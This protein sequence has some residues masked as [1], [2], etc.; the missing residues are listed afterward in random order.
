MATMRSSS[1]RDGVTPIGG[2]GSVSRHQLQQQPSGPD[3]VD[4]AAT[5]DQLTAM[6]GYSGGGS[7]GLQHLLLAS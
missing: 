5:V 4:W 1:P 7:S 2:G 3:G 6:S